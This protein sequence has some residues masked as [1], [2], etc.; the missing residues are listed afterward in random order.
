MNSD[1]SAPITPDYQPENSEYS[2]Y[3]LYDKKTKIQY[4]LIVVWKY[5]DSCM[6]KMQNL[7]E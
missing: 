5:K 4:E 3:E 1:D 6:C 7:D 2:E